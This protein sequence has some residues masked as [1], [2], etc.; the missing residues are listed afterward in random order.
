[1]SR[2]EVIG[3]A[4][5]YMGD[6]MEILPTLTTEWDR[7]AFTSPP[8]NLG[9]GMEDKGGLRVGHG[10]SKWRD[11]KL[12]DGYEA[13]NDAM[14]YREYAAWQKAVLDELFRVCGAVFYNHKPR[15]VKRSLRLPFFASPYVNAH[16]RQI[17]IWDRASG[18]NYMSGAFMPQHEWVMV[19]A[20]GSWELRDKAASGFGD[21]WRVPP[22]IDPDHPCS[23]PVALP[24]IALESSGAESA[25]DPFMGVGTTG[26][27]AVQL[28]KKFVGIELSPSYFDIACRRIEQ[29]YKQ[30]PL[31][32]AEP[33]RKPEQLGLEAQS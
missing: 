7:I 14:P 8:Y 9:E 33:A 13:H 15:V 22:S 31:F 17:V 4:T 20:Q 2:V 24:R 29:A 28:G 12:R 23:F 25:L 6:C 26:V 1:V 27:A 21:V 16:L 32:E 5:L 3:D 11:G 19:Y 18:F 30:R 10:G